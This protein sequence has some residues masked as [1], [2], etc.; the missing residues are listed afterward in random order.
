[1][2]RAVTIE[3]RFSLAT[4][5]EDDLVA[6]L[7]GL[8]VAEL[9][10]KVE[11]DGFG[12]GRP[13]FLVPKVGWRRLERHVARARD[14]GIG[15][16][17]LLNA[18]DAGTGESAS[19]PGFGRLRDHLR[20]IESIGASS[21]TVLSPLH[22]RMVV[23]HTALK[24]RVSVFARVDDERKAM[25][26]FEA[27]ANR[28]VLDSMLVNRDPVR[29]ERIV[30]ASAGRG[31]LELLVNNRCEIG[32]AWAP[33][34]AADLGAASR[35]AAPSPD[36]CY[37][38]C[39][40]A[41]LRNPARLLIQ[42]WIRPEDLPLYERIG[43]RWFKIAGRGCTT[44]DLV[45]RARAYADRRFDGNLMDLLRRGRVRVR[46]STGIAALLRGGWRHL[47][48][49]ARVAAPAA[50]I[51]DGIRIENRALDGYLEL[52]FKKGGCLPGK[53]RQCDLCESRA[54][55]AVSFPPGLADDIARIDRGLV[56]GAIWGDSTNA[57]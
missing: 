53:C 40:S 50:A 13:H 12:G 3:S 27:G 25:A 56:T 11:G 42:D 39:Q 1:M 9:Y 46:A 5:Y 44:D 24:A 33:C 38:Q 49:L 19:A 18:A 6:R 17:Y 22:L 45:A 36:A 7:E 35:R 55:G 10:G 4:S 43:Y 32:C 14:A 20:R 57:C 16:N 23:V 34:H 54:R 2:E 26:W 51:E 8:P 37:F 30:R 47:R 21:V 48:G 41:F 52:V 28:I 31:E 15:F 29:L